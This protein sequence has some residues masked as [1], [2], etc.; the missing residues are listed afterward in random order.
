MGLSNFLYS[1]HCLLHFGS[2][3]SDVPE[4]EDKWNFKEL[5][6]FNFAAVFGLYD[7]VPHIFDK[8]LVHAV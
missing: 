6:K 1:D 4:T 8:H 5:K 7:N 3:H 2:L